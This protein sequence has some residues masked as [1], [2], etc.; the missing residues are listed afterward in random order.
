[1]ASPV[2]KLRAVEPVGPRYADDDAVQE[3]AEGLPERFLYC[4]EM[5]HNW[6]P[7]TASAYRDGGFER[8][9]RCTRCKTRR[10]Q[11]ISN[12]G[13]IVHNRYEY[14]EGYSAP[15]GMG[16]IAGEGRGV[17]RLASIKRIVGKG[18]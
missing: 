11:E 13:V 18:D 15:K 7:Y 6:K 16:Q 12:R 9:L 3:F 8:V 10:H 1:M 5:G 17:L 2:R 14:P 4:R